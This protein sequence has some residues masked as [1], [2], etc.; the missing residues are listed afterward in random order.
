ML[1]LVIC[2][3]CG[4]AFELDKIV[5]HAIDCKGKDA[6]AAVAESPK[7]QEAISGASA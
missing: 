7:A 3:K 1:H 5:K 2:P 6:K 4:Q